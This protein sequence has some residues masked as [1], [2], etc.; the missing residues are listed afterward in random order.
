MK[1]DK[2]MKTLQSILVRDRT[3][4]EKRKTQGDGVRNP[5]L[6]ASEITGI[7]ASIFNR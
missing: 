1:Q 3:K 4:Y 5:A 2:S 7:T 6:N